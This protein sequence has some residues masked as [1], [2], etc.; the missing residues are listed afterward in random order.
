MIQIARRP[1]LL[2]FPATGTSYPLTAEEADRL[3][4]AYPV[5]HCYRRRLVLR[6]DDGQLCSIRPATLDSEAA[7]VQVRP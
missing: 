5:V 6:A 4:A 7:F 2:T 3:V 1:Y